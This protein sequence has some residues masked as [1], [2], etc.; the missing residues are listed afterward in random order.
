[1]YK[2]VTQDM[3]SKVIFELQ[4]LILIW[5]VI[6]SLSFMYYTQVVEEQNIS[7]L[8]SHLTKNIEQSASIQ[9]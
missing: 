2:S 6:L 3:N 4:S 1:M 9:L 8:G 7:G 5:N